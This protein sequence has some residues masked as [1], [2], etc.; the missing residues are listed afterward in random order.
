M[1]TDLTLS[2]RLPSNL[3]G[4][5]FQE[6]E[7]K[8]MSRLAGDKLIDSEILLR[9][10]RIGWKP[11]WASASIIAIL[12]LWDRQ[13]FFQL[14]KSIVRAVV[15]NLHLLDLSMQVSLFKRAS[16]YGEKFES[17]VRST[18]SKSLFREELVAS[19]VEVV[20]PTIFALL[21][22]KILALRAE[23][24]GAFG[25]WNRLWCINLDRVGFGGCEVCRP[26]VMWDCDG[27]T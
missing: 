13:E 8:R 12:T 6:F 20:F 26:C 24:I 3:L 4:R 23:F 14:E 15:T 7:S 22:R 2:A 19:L 27:R 11:E 21:N 5:L 25:L 16:S 9:Y 18:T 10:G 1:S 17:R